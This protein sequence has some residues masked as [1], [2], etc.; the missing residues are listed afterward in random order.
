MKY[1]KNYWYCLGSYLGLGCWI[2]GA[3]IVVLIEVRNFSLSQ[4][5]RLRQ[6]L[7]LLIHWRCSR[8]A[9]FVAEDIACLGSKTQSLSTSTYEDSV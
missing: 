7:F 2:S 9:G 5:F 8:P 6:R 4:P 1:Q 3:A